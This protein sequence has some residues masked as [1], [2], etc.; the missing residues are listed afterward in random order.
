MSNTPG[1]TGVPTP[2]PTGAPT[3][4]ETG[5]PTHGPTGA[6]TPGGAVA[7]G[8]QPTPEASSSGAGVPAANGAPPPTQ[9]PPAGAA[10]PPATG[11]PPLTLTLQPVLHPTDIPTWRGG[12]G[13]RKEAHRWLAHLRK[14]CAEAGMEAI[15]I[16]HGLPQ[17]VAPPDHAP[18]L[19]FEWQRYLCMHPQAAFLVATGVTMFE[20]RFLNSR[21][22]NAR[23]L[24]LPAPYGSYRFDFLAHRSDGLCVRLHPSQSADAQ[25]VVG[26]L[27]AWTLDRRAPT[28]AYRPPPH[29]P[30]VHQTLGP[31]DVISAE[32]CE[33]IMTDRL[34]STALKEQI[35][36]A[37]VSEE[38][39]NCDWFDFVRFLRARPWG[40]KLLSEGVASLT[41]VADSA[42]TPVQPN[43][44][45]ITNTNS[46]PRTI[47]FR[48]GRAYL[49]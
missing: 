25:A 16:T 28:P 9:A 13:M 22:P 39:V 29:R 24:Q 18:T 7:N 12:G 5:A 48:G 19:V 40:E 27:A 32:A 2:G 26:E 38:L 33:R 3:P 36:P 47:S 11:A 34:M 17:G 37:E 8:A 10:P 20:G 41:L 30:T 21:E 31:V 15:D 23:Q 14:H 44:R 35:A 1:A 6:P 49:T 43:I 4:G 42:S 46:A 45:V